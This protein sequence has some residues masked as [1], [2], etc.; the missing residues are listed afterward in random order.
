MSDALPPLRAVAFDL[1]GTLADSA[2]GICSTF[3]TVLGEAGHPIPPTAE[4]AAMIGLPL[5]D[6]MVRYA[7]GATDHDL[8]RMISRYKWIYASSVVPATLL[9]P[10]AWSLLRACRAAGLELA[11]V[12]GKTT[13]V[14]DA[15]LRRCRIRGLFKVVVGNERASRPKPFPD[16]LHLALDELGAPAE[17]TLLVGDGTHDIEM[18]RG[19]GTRTCGVAWGVHHADHLRDA[20]ADHVVHSMAELRHLILGNAPTAV[21]SD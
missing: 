21:Y 5:A 18:G 2:P 20:G 14:A 4:I 10:R 12:T 6:I 7:P 1:D 19:A 15:V 13:D 17:Q 9:F 8:A 16:L 11:I 3:S